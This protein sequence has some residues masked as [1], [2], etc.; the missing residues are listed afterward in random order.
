MYI[1]TEMY[2]GRGRRGGTHSA[3]TCQEM[4]SFLMLQY[5]FLTQGCSEV[6]G[7]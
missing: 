2:F 3:R 7:G 4:A 5:A 6:A 1:C